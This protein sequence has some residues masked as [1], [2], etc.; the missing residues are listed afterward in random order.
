MEDE[1]NF[2]HRKPSTGAKLICVGN[3]YNDDVEGS[4]ISIAKVRVR[5]MM[6]FMMMMIDDDVKEGGGG[7]REE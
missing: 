4:L 3:T 1:N 5:M 7:S 6:I 2:P